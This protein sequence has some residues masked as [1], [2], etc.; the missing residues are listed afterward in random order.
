MIRVPD[1]TA[2]LAAVTTHGGA[3]VVAP[4]TLP[5]VGSRCYVTDPAG[6]LIGLHHY[7]VD[8]GGSGP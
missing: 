2:A 4:F 7:D 3:V 8:D 5:G 6:V 1:L